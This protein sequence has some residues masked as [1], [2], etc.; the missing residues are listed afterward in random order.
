[1]LTKVAKKEDLTAISTLELCQVYS[2]DTFRSPWTVFQVRGSVLPRLIVPILLTVGYSVL[3]AILL[4][5]EAEKNT[6]T[7]LASNFVSILSMVLGLM[8]GF[9][10]NQAYDRY[11][12]GRKQ[13]TAL[14]GVN[15]VVTRQISLVLDAAFCRSLDS[16][17]ELAGAGAVAPSSP[18]VDL[19]LRSACLGISRLTLAYALALKHYLRQEDGWFH[20]DLLTMV[21]PDVIRRLDPASADILDRAGYF[22]THSE[23]SRATILHA[24]RTSS[25]LTSFSD[26][27][28]DEERLANAR[29]CSPAS[30]APSEKNHIVR[31]ASGSRASVLANA[32]ASPHTVDS[33][34][35]LKENLVPLLL[36]RE[37]AAQITRAVHGR[38]HSSSSS[39]TG[40]DAV[41]V[42]LLSP[43]SS[44]IATLLEIFGAC[45]RILTTPSP[46]A[47]KV[48]L[49]QIITLY[50]MALP[51]V[52]FPALGWSFILPMMLSTF[53]FFGIEG[54]SAELENPFGYDRNDLPLDVYC[55]QMR[56]EHQQLMKQAE[57]Y[58]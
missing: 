14:A 53:I 46:F 24:L 54:I 43:L 20:E 12:E 41:Q 5:P 50:I 40:N 55:D 38:P 15:R 30:S 8:L 51:V 7:S 16:S 26:A 45:E 4:G 21:N 36:N 3:F 18:P 1:M 39:S 31:T 42:A 13:W 48:F 35:P 23:R 49:K 56:F 57:I 19:R 25:T 58:L 47:L 9:R 22:T 11:W 44:Q 33:A 37:L 2:Y 28:A 10:S 52:L 27:A 34:M 29:A 32:P 6:R 17:E